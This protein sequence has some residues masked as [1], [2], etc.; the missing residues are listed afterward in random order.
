MPRPL[1]LASGS[2]IRLAL[3]K[4]AALD[5]TAIPARVDE[6]GVRHSLLATGAPARDVADALAGLKARKVANRHPDALVLGCDQVLD[7]QGVILS[8]PETPE[9]A[10][11]Q[12][13]TLRGHTHR[14]LSALVLHDGPDAIWRHVGV[15]TLTMRPAGDV[16]LRGYVSRNWPAIGG[17][18][19]SYLIESE[20][21]RLFSALEGDYFT[22]LGLPML[23]LLDYL[24]LRGFIE[25]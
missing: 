25:I 9:A 11:D 20:G 15:A 16:W 7:F 17:S 18:A 24:A 5:V 22:V 23:P 21:I 1:I 4:A 10:I 8:K 19:G 3:L 2:P 14:L 12:L 13:R 6:A